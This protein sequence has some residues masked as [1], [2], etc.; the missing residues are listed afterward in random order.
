MRRIVRGAALA[1]GSAA[2][3]LCTAACGADRPAGD[4]SAARLTAAILSKQDLPSDYLPAED[5][6]VFRGVG[7]ADPSCR[8]LLDLADLRGLRDVPVG[9]AFFFRLKPAATLAEHLVVLGQADVRGYLEQARK[10]AQ[11]CHTMLMPEA[12]ELRLRRQWITSLPPH[13]LGVRYSAPADA[14]HSIY[15]DLV[16][17][18][19]GD[20]LMI[21]V[22][23]GLVDDTQG[24]RT[25]DTDSIA[26]MA[27]RKLQAAHLP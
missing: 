20:R 14:R 5:Q 27:L 25:P 7:P 10:A 17:V 8:R 15:F 19:I 22:Q 11:R 3:A 18:P 21:V 4:S 16:M 12:D 13:A 2:A 6:Q 1:G 23:P 9:H 26:T 24:G